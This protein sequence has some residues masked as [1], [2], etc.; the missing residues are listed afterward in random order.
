MNKNIVLIGGGHGLSNLVKGFKGENINLSVIVSATDDGGHTGK[1]R[2]EF[3]CVAIGDLRRVLYE[4]LDERSF[5]KEVFDY[6]FTKVHGIKNLSLGNLIIT[7]LL[8]KYHD[9][10]NVISYFKE[11]ENFK[12]NVYLS[13]NN[14]VTLCA[15]YN[16]GEIVESEEKI[17]CHNKNV[18]KIYVDEDT[19]CNLEMLKSIDLADVIVLSP[20]SLYTS[21]G[22]VLCIEQIKEHLIRTK[23]EIVY[24]CNIMCQY[25]E[26]CNYTVKDH[27]RALEKIMGRKIDRIIVNI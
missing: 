10:D 11:K 23:A 16:D 27:V 25:G 3:D 2:D 21:I 6:R 8:N 22:S 13:C 24:T 5:L 20:G 26:T 15:K 18:E 19:I 4:L 7:A 9:I 17:G 12:T 1:I 14:S